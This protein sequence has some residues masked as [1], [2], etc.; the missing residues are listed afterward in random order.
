MQTHGQCLL[1]LLP[2]LV[3]QEPSPGSSPS[4]YVNAMLSAS[5]MLLPRQRTYLRSSWRTV[6]QMK[7]KG[8]VQAG[9][10]ADLVVFD[11]ATVRPGDVRPTQPNKR[12]NEARVGQR[13]VRGSGR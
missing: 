11:L 5:L 2:T 9:M 6:P 1:T 4:M 7:K 12:R 8:R 10:D 13:R 3:A